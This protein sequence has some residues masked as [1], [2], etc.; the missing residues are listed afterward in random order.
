MNVIGNKDSVTSIP[1]EIIS[2]LREQGVTPECEDKLVKMFGERGKR[3]LKTVISKRVKKYVLHPSGRIR[4]IIVGRNEEYLVIPVVKYC[5]CKDFFFYVMTGEAYMCYHLLA[6]RIAELTGL[7]SEVE[8]SD[9]VYEKFIAS[10]IFI[11]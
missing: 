8:E 10:R 11:Y 1:E 3:A 6:Q 4:W 5:S 9:E 7:F 2:V